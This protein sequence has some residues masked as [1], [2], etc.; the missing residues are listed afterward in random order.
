MR[1]FSGDLENYE[2]N[3]RCIEDVV[4]RLLRHMKGLD[5]SFRPNITAN[6]KFSQK[7]LCGFVKELLSAWAA[8]HRDGTFSDPD[9]GESLAE[10]YLQARL[11]LY[12]SYLYL[13]MRCSLVRGDYALVCGSRGVE[14][15]P[16]FSFLL[17]QAKRLIRDW[18][19]MKN[20]DGDKK[21]DLFWGY[22]DYFGLHLYRVLSSHPNA[23][24]DNRLV[25]EPYY[26][27]NA[28]VFLTD[29]GNVKR[30]FLKKIYLSGNPF[31]RK[32][33]VWQPDEGSA[34]DGE[35][36]DIYDV[37]GDYEDETPEEDGIW[38]DY[39]FEEGYDDPE[40]EYEAGCRQAQKWADLEWLY[41]SFEC[42]EEYLETCR[43]FVKEF[44]EAKPDVL[45]GFYEDLEEIVTLYLVGRGIP[46]LMDMDE[47][48]NVY[49]GIYDGPCAQA[50][51]YARGALWKNL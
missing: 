28:P 33:E 50:A 42:S 13:V 20:P 27:V 37:E 26:P 49:S 3:L 29:E 21:N 2:K 40:W 30:T 48:L 15:R 12:G 46:P 41:T 17:E 51:R 6:Q 7:K 14:E 43:L 34:D 18:C 38:E 44:Q 23:G 9:T 1:T 25:Y 45:R 4:D 8:K 35:E 24:L 11:K 22:D 19:V 36:E 10:E 32:E 47:T 5:V 31:H 16:S 39:D